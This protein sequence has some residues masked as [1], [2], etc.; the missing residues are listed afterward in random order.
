MR[1]YSCLFLALSAVLA[2]AARCQAA[3]N[4]TNYGF[5]YFLLSR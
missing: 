3:N 4:S 5:D 2:I 1:P